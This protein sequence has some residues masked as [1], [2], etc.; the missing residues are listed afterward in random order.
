MAIAALPI[1]ADR[2]VRQGLNRMP[3]SPARAASRSGNDLRLA[4]IA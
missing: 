3:G 1:A 2:R 4:G